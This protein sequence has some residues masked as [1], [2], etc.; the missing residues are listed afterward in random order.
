MIDS[1][2]ARAGLIV[3]SDRYEAA[4]VANDTATLDELFWHDERVM[5]IAPAEEQRGIETIRQYR[6]NRPLNELARAYLSRE[7]VSFGDNAGVVN[8]V[9]QRTL[10]GRI[11]R[12]SQTWMRLDGEWRIV[13]AHISFRPA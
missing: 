3:A 7:V 10:D 12:Q 9:F 2:I 11:G 8:L 4:L 6:A 5:R 13:S 1:P